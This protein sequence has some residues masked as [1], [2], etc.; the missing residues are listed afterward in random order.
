MYWQQIS[1]VYFFLGQF[2]VAEYFMCIYLAYCKDEQTLISRMSELVIFRQ[3]AMNSSIETSKPLQVDVQERIVVS[4]VPL[5]PAMAASSECL[6]YY[7]NK[8]LIVYNL[9]QPSKKSIPWTKRDGH[10]IDICWYN[11]KQCIILTKREFHLLNVDTGTVNTVNRLPVD[12]PESNYHRCTSSSESLML[13]FSCSGTAIEEWT[14]KERT[15]LWRPPISCT[16]DEHICCLRLSSSILGL[17][18]AD[19]KG[20][21]RFELRQRDTMSVL[22]VIQLNFQSYRFAPIDDGNWLLVPYYHVRQEIRIVDTKARTIRTVTI[23]LLAEAFSYNGNYNQMIW[24]VAFVPGD[25]SRLIVQRE[26]TVCFF[27]IK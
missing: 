23:P 1:G 17:T 24:N 2:T 13:C 9:K 6:I 27:K 16:R 3:K 26:K 18:L 11:N 10:V 8:F 14:L 7:E 25:N 4:R 22:R 21:S 12:D 19:S 15:H 5:Y 20:R